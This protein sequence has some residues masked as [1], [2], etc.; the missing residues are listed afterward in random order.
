MIFA[1][2]IIQKWNHVWRWNVFV[3]ELICKF[4]NYFG[5]VYGL[6]H[7]IQVCCCKYDDFFSVTYF[8]YFTILQIFYLLDGMEMLID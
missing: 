4:I 8:C 5:I 7:V 6:M 2:L 1:S 3:N